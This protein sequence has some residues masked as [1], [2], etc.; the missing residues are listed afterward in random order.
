M[1]YRQKAQNY[2]SLLK[3]ALILGITLCVLGYAIY[4]VLTLYKQLNKTQNGTI[5]EQPAQE[6]QGGTTSETQEQTPQK[7]GEGQDQPGTGNS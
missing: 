2:G 3:A 6:E 1:N 7:A 5:R 4:L